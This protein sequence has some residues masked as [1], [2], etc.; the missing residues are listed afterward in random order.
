MTN[1]LTRLNYLQ[2]SSTNSQ[3]QKITSFCR[4]IPEAVHYEIEIKVLQIL[5]ESKK[6]VV[7]LVEIPKYVMERHDIT[8][9]FKD[10]LFNTEQKFWIYYLHRLIIDEYILGLGEFCVVDG[11][12]MFNDFLIPNI[13]IDGNDVI[14]R[15]CD[16]P[17]ED[18]YNDDN[19]II[20]KEEN[21][22]KQTKEKK[23]YEVIDFSCS[24]KLS[25]KFCPIKTIF[26]KFLEE[27]KARRDNDLINQ[28]NIICTYN[29]ERNRIMINERNLNVL[30]NIDGTPLTPDYLLHE[31]DFQER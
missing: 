22:N 27:N 30:S 24:K 25:N 20:S 18:E 14:N 23:W 2:N 1:C 4:E 12:H 7:T 29:D 26:D 21:D 17:V 6:N 3:L 13:D 11:F 16:I 15:N 28:L 5:R 31:I 8:F 19:N 10:F 9:P